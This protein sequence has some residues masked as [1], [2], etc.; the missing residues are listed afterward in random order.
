[1]LLITTLKI[2]DKKVRLGSHLFI[3]VTFCVPDPPVGR[4]MASPQ[5]LRSLTRSSLAPI[6]LYLLSH[7]QP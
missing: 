4:L 2:T 7:L 3:L 5:L 1:M 6:T